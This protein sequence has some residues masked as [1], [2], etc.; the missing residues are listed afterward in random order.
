MKKNLKAIVVAFL[1]LIA[2]AILFK[3]SYAYFTADIGG[4]ETDVTLTMG[5]GKIEIDFN[6]GLSI[7]STGLKPKSAPVAVK[8][9]TVKGSNTTDLNALML[10]HLVLVVESNEL[11][12]ESLGY[13]LIGTNTDNNGNTIPNIS[14]IKKINT[15]SG[16]YNLGVGEFSGTKISNKTHTYALEIYFPETGEKQNDN[17]GKKFKMHIEVRD[18]VTLENNTSSTGTLL[19]ENHSGIYEAASEIKGI[20]SITVNEGQ[21]KNIS[22]VGNQITYELEGGAERVGETTETCT[23]AASVTAGTKGACAAY[24]CAQ[25]TLSG[26]SC[27]GVNGN[28][29]AYVAPFSGTCYAPNNCSIPANYF[30]QYYLGICPEPYKSAYMLISGEPATGGC[31]CNDSGCGCGINIPAAIISCAG[32]NMTIAATCSTYNYSCPSGGT[33][34]GTTCYSCMQGIYN[35]SVC[36]WSCQENYSYYTYNV[37]FEYYV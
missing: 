8:N 35:G 6:G 27:T 25:G 11:T 1:I 37:T 13:K 2:G 14:T 31:G 5:S 7:T 12:S 17:Q 20:K 9:F 3:F 32:T 23:G 28:T 16:E 10:Y 19:V 36:S 26:T 33:L 29:I 18:Q 4:T 22:F 15:G 21:V 34:S 24:S 30:Q